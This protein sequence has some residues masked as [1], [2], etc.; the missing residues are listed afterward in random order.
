MSREEED[1]KMQR[2]AKEKSDRQRALR[3]VSGGSY[4]VCSV[5]S[6]LR[7]KKSQ[8]WAAVPDRR[9]GTW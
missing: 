8:I 7:K 6:L 9:G 1:R 3:S 5:H 2:P 4:C